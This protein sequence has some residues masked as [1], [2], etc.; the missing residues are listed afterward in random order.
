[1]EIDVVRKLERQ[2]HEGKIFM[3][4]RSSLLPAVLGKEVTLYPLKHL[5]LDNFDRLKKSGIQ[6]LPLDALVE[7]FWKEINEA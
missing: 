7:L 3:F 5:T 1:M 4:S 6:N 2:G